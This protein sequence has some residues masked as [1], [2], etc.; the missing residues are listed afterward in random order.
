MTAPLDFSTVTVTDA[1]PAFA[2]GLASRIVD[3]H[4]VSE[5]CTVVVCRAC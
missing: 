1:M 4:G 3:A 5:H 2:F